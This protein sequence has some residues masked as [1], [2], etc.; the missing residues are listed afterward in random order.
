MLARERTGRLLPT[1]NLRSRSRQQSHSSQ[2]ASRRMKSECNLDTRNHMRLFARHLV[3]C[4]KEI[5]D[6]NHITGSLSGHRSNDIGRPLSTS[7][8]A[9]PFAP[10]TC[11]RSDHIL[12]VRGAEDFPAYAN[13]HSHTRYPLKFLAIPSGIHLGPA[14]QKQPWLRSLATREYIR[15]METLPRLTARS[16]NVNDPTLITLVN[17]LQDVFTTVGVCD[18]GPIT[19]VQEST[20]SGVLG[21]K[22]D[23]PTTN[24]RRWLSVEREEFG[25]REYRGKRFVWSPPR[26]SA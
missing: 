17:K 16:I 24:S 21:T 20:D 8:A 19:Q 10:T 23:R 1:N 18:F 4:R 11:C 9:N 14:I 12:Q 22:S 2:N 15:K 13:E 6:A 7:N 3:L 26:R 25:T 5:K